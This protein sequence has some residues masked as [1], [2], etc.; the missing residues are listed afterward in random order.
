[1]YRRWIGLWLV[2]VCGTLVGC[3]SSE[4]EYPKGSIP[5]ISPSHGRKPPG[6]EGGN[7]PVTP[8]QPK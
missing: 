4:P 6:A 3:G 1:M 8:E 5:D 7:A 2:V